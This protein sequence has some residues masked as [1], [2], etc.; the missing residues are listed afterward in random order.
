MDLC[1]CEDSSHH[2][3]GI[4]QVL[5]KSTATL[6]SKKMFQRFFIYFIIEEYLTILKATPYNLTTNYHHKRN[7]KFV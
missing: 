7:N 4:S 3:E 2:I 1:G 6:N 5:L